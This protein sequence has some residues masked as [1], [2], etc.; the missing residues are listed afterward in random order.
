M[1]VIIPFIALFLV[2]HILRADDIALTDG[3]VLK[4]AQVVQQDDS[5][6]TV[7][8]SFSGGVAQVR[9]AMMPAMVATA[10]QPSASTP[11]KE[12][13]APSLPSSQAPENWSVNGRDY[14]DV[15][16]TQVEADRVHITYDGG[17]GTVMLADLPPEL[18]K[19][20][21][22]DPA[23]AHQAEQ[24]R[25]QRASQAAAELAAQS[26][27]ADAAQSRAQEMAKHPCYM[28]GEVVQKLKDG[29]L[30]QCDKIYG[31]YGVW[32]EFKLPPGLPTGTK[33]IYGQFLLTNYP[34]QDSMVDG[35]PVTTVAY[36]TGAFSYT[37]VRGSNATIASYTAVLPGN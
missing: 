34:N 16:V 1:K 10:Q 19:R 6:K 27:N 35:D 9:A 4:N 8:I 32:I 33:Q 15:K 21:N 28:K 11:A 30:V 14:H 24:T 36:R 26:A 13:S 5:T 20:F 3:T 29:L 12:S 2:I 31:E 37:T 18:Q 23:A 25:A 22:F 7:T 17:L